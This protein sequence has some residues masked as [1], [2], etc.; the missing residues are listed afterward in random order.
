MKFNIK[1]HPT[2][3]VKTWRSAL[4]SCQKREDRFI[5]L[6]YLYQGDYVNC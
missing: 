3:A 5:L 2:A 1:H 4:G 6:S